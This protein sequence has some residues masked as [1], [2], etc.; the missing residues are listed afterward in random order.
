MMSS[1]TVT[2]QERTGSPVVAD[3]TVHDSSR[4]QPADPWLGADKF[5]HIALSAY[6]LGAQMYIYQ[7]P[8]GL[9]ERRALGLAVTGTAVI[10]IGKEIYDGVSGRGQASFK[11]LAADLLGIAL[12]SLLFMM[13]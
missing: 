13:D 8:L 7:Q 6:L 5:K 11:D 4:V 2:A 9:D 10:G 12:G 1:D 3:S